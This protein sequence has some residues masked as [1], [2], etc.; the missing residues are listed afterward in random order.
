MPKD[1]HSYDI[2]FVIINR[3]SKQ[4]ISMPCYKTVIAEDIARLFISHVYRY[5]GPLQ[6][7]V[8]DRGL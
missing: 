4:A 7:I 5:Y 8:L 6:T 3:L 1:K 2:I